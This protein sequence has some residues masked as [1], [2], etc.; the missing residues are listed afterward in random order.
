[1][2]ESVSHK[3]ACKTAPGILGLLISY[4]HTIPNPSYNT[5]FC[6]SQPFSP[7]ETEW[8]AMLHHETPAMVSK[9]FQV[10]G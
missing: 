3:A 7:D 1:M 2:N 6:G 5:R 9:P 8:M 10:L 4:P